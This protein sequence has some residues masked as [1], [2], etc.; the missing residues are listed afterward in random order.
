MSGYTKEIDGDP[1]IS[2]AGIALLFGISEELCNAE[3]K[4]Q[5]S[6]GAEGFVPPGEWIRNGRRRQKEYQ[7]AT[8]RND[9]QGA[10][11]YWAAQDQ[12]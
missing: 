6:T 9:M 2:T 11:E 7:A 3:I 12:Q 5:R 4:R 1:M 8:G 10:L